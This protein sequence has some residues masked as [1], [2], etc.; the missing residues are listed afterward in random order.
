MNFKSIL[1]L[2]IGLASP[3]TIAAVK[4]VLGTLAKF[5]QLKGDNGQDITPEQ[6]AVL[7]D[8]ARA[9]FKTLGDEA[10]A[11]NAAIGT[12]FGGNG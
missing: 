11:S 12:A 8:E 4:A 2:V 10:A 7:W 1:S 5:K 6:L 9:E 3:Q